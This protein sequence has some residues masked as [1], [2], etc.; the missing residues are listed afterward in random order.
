[1]N[2]QA[3]SIYLNPVLW[4]DAKQRVEIYD[5]SILTTD[6][7]FSFVQRDESLPN[8]LLIGDSIS[9]SYTST[10]R[11]LLAG[12]ANVYR[13]PTNGG[14]TGRGLEYIDFWLD[15]I[16]WAILHFNWGLHDI[17]RFNESVKNHEDNPHKDPIVTLANRTPVQE[18]LSRLR[19]L[20]ARMK[21]TDAKLIWAA[22]TPVPEGCYYFVPGDEVLYNNL[23][24]EIMDEEQI[25]TNDLHA[26]IRMHLPEFQD[27]FDIHF[28]EKGAES[29]G[30]KTAREILRHL[31]MG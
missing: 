28:N 12:K 1:M 8:V 2:R 23:A 27:P 18:Y 14:W 3:E 17:K 25:E 24:R 16:P 15:C 4:E 22:T 6:P 13:V 5:P 31:S 26:H 20:I 10:V 30:G 29:L 21:V 9:I 19:T 7:A 11:L